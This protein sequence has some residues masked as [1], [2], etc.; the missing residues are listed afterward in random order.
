[1]G[2]HA[3]Q[4]PAC[5]LITLTSP[6][7]H[8]RAGGWR[9]HASTPDPKRPESKKRGVWGDSALLS[10]GR[11]RSGGSGTWIPTTSCWRR[12][13]R[14]TWSMGCCST[15]CFRGTAWRYRAPEHYGA[16]QA[17]PAVTRRDACP[18]SLLCE[19]RPRAAGPSSP[20]SFLPHAFAFLLLGR[21]LREAPPVGGQQACSVAHSMSAF[22]G[23][24]SPRALSK[25]VLRAGNTDGSAVK[26][27][28]SMWRALGPSPAL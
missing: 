25:Q 19:Q 15:S 13:R 10:L 4:L 6:G 28:H 21:G 24:S 7:F 26:L 12:T 8:R 18:R 16:G 9:L 5:V 2:A 27:L 1:M 14:W 3:P 11:W 23:P 17:L 20:D 22:C